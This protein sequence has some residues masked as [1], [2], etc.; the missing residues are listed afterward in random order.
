MNVGQQTIEWLYSTQ[1][2]IDDEWAIRQPNG[3]TWWAYLNAQTVEILGEQEGP[4][5]Q[6]GYLIGI[7]T[8]LVHNLDLTD[9]AADDICT[10][11]MRT[12]ALSGPVYDEENRCLQLCSMALV[13][14][15]NAEWMKILLSA[16]AATQLAEAMLL[17]PG[18][19]E[20]LGAEPAVSGHLDSGLREEPDEIA[21]A[22]RIFVEDGQEPCRWVAEDFEQAVRQ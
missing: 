19:A 12:A 16:A 4:D 14:D 2:Q 22:A 15:E 21:L 9:Q 7:R 5:G 20:Q 17:G 10:G 1:L 8:D 11:P 3:F 13:H 18:L 6:T